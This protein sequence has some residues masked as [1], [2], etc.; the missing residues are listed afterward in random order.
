MKKSWILGAFLVCLCLAFCGHPNL[1][2]ANTGPKMVLKQQ[3]EIDVGEVKQGH[4]IE[5]TFIVRNEGDA[6]LEVKDV[7][8]G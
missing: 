6:T 4:G 5:Q 8:H 3:E 1:S 2:G 7:R